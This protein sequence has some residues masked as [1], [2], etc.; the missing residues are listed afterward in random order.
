MVPLGSL[1]FEWDS[2]LALIHRDKIKLQ[3]CASYE[4]FEQDIKNKLGKLTETK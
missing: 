4:F 1:Y 3:T 2:P